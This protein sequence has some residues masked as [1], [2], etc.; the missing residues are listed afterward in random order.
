MTAT[1]AGKKRLVNDRT[2]GY[3]SDRCRN[4]QAVIVTIAEE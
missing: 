1:I 4:D 3:L 2:E